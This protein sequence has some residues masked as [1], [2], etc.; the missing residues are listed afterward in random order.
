MAGMDHM[1][2]TETGRTLDRNHSGASLPALTSLSAS[3]Q[4]VVSDVS[5]TQSDSFA[6]IYLK[7]LDSR[8]GRF[9]PELF[10]RYMT[11][12]LQAG[13]KRWRPPVVEENQPS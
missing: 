2:R 11:E 6:H 8:S 1:R 4:I 3:I 9:I 13:K 12:L 7:S 5:K 10:K